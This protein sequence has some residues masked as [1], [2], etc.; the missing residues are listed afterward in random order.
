MIY[1]KK[2]IKNH[3]LLALWRSILIM[4]CIVV[5]D[6][7]IVTA[8]SNSFDV[9]RQIVTLEYPGAELINMKEKRLT[10]LYKERT[11]PLYLAY[12]K[13]LDIDEDGVV[14][15]LVACQ[16][17]DKG[18]GDARDVFGVYTLAQDN[19]VKRLFHQY[20]DPTDKGE[21]LD[22]QISDVTGTGSVDI[23]VTYMFANAGMHVWDAD[24]RLYIIRGH[25][26][27]DTLFELSLREGTGGDGTE[28][29]IKRTIEIHDSDHDGIN[30][31]VCVSYEGRDKFSLTK[32]S[33][34][35]TYRARFQLTTYALEELRHHGVPEDILTKLL[36][37]KDEHVVNKQAFLNRIEDLI[38]H[39]DL[40]VYQT[41]FVQYALSEYQLE[42]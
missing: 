24:D 4:G 34:Q 17:L 41:K 3:L 35:Q 14:E 9:L 20:F 19:T 18:F 25:V 13:E 15:L 2:D 42:H 26:P 30:E 23:S 31:I 28:H 10:I 8:E 29:L 7:D 27:F 1:L 21:F 36:P 12:V 39:D 40:L 22:I 16:F 37:L 6:V 5:Y 33:V 32:N 38:G 11:M